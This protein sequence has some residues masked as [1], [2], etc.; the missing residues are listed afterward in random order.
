M[1]IDVGHMSIRWMVGDGAGG[2]G[3]VGGWEV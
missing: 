1:H 2:G 3:G